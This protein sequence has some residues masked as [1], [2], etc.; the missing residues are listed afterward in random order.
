[1]NRDDVVALDQADPLAPLR[2]LFDL[3]EETI[4]LDGNSLGALPRATAGR[5]AEVVTQEWGR[6]LI[7]SWNTASWITL[8]QRVGDKIA[9]I[10]GAGEGEVVV[11]DSTSLNVYK[12]LASA[13]SIASADAPERR[14]VISERSNFPTDLYIASSLCRERGYELVLVDSPDE[15]EGLL[16]RAAVLMLTE[17]NYRTG[18]LHDMAAVTA[19][20]HEHGVLAVWDL[21]HSAGAVPVDLR[22]ADADFAVGC[23][24]KFLNGGP[25]AP[26]FL[27]VNPRHVDRFEQPLSGWMGHAAPF[28]M[29]PGY[30]PAEGVSRYLSGTP[31]VIGISA[32]ECGVD[33]LLAAEAY[34][35]LRAVREKSLALTRH[36]ADLVASRLPG[37]VIES[38]LDDARRGS[39]LSLSL[40]SG[41]GAYAIVQALIERGVIG[42]FRAGS[43]DILR[44]GVTPLYTRYVDIWDAVDHLVAVMD[45]DEWRAERFWTRGAVT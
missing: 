23:G 3:P 25:G 38:P 9:R 1:M 8:P 42:D 13:L 45:N 29:S 20:A 4:Y 28:E 18:Y 22:G 41:E 12:A 39:Q 16:D 5:V 6:G 11:A 35:G 34:G 26:A 10:V 44:F 43:P 37:F 32:L 36:F 17:V 14:I 24:Y 30:R 2:D 21:C 19:R 31:A 27:W 15:I 40:G 7:E 33:T